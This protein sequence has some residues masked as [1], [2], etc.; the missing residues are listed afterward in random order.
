MSGV[1][2]P[3]RQLRPSS[4]REHVKSFKQSVRIE[5]QSAVCMVGSLRS[6]SAVGGSSGQMK[7]RIET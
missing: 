6:H 4:R 1:L 2:T 5:V 3:C 7:E